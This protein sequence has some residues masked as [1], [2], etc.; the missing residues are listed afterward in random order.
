[1]LKLCIALCVAAALAEPNQDREDGGPP[2]ALKEFQ[3]EPD[4]YGVRYL[5]ESNNS[6]SPFV[7]ASAHCLLPEFLIASC[8]RVA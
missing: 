4:Q 2:K 5:H 1:M 3:K 6:E 7:K 8:V